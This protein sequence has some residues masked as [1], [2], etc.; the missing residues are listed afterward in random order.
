MNYVT[1]QTS[2]EDWLEQDL[3]V[4]II[5]RNLRVRFNKSIHLKKNNLTS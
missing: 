1:M 3:M 5:N 4:L 2:V